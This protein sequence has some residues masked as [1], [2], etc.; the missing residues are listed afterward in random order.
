M[1]N[2]DL[3]GLTDYQGR[4]EKNIIKGFYRDLTILKD[5]H[6]DIRVN[7]T[8]PIKLP[9]I[10]GTDGWRMYDRTV[11]TPYSNSSGVMTERELRARVGMK[12]FGFELEELRD[13]FL[14]EQ[15]K[16]NDRQLQAFP[17]L[18]DYLMKHA[19][20]EI[21][22]DAWKME[23]AGAATAYSAVATYAANALIKFDEDGSYHIYKNISG[24][25]T[26]AGESPVSAAAK[27]QKVTQYSITDG[28][29]KIIADEI[30]ATNIS[31]VTTGAVSSS[32][33]VDKFELMY[34]ALAPEVRAKGSIMLCSPDMKLHYIRN[35]RSAHGAVIDRSEL[36]KP[37]SIDGSGGKTMIIAKDW[38]AGT[39]RIIHTVPKN[40]TIGVDQISDTTKM[41]P[42]IQK[43]HGFES[44]LKI[45]L[46]FQI[47][48]ISAD[49]FAVNDQE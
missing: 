46:G 15:A 3:T 12:L 6:L 34:N 9:K 13:K 5:P 44:N 2:M 49:L 22:R 30:D 8:V 39:N 19:A 7:A 18:F 29:G 37:L 16:V 17:W 33:A 26:T 20:N 38:M 41:G 36:D 23:Y 32:N 45:M 4:Y 47:A 11:E 48:D 24:S 14:A 21:Q 25:T 35:Y 42:I 27:W 10:E 40:L 28:W 31:P 1:A 43:H